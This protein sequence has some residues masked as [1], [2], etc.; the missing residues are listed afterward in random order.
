MTS[1][2]APGIAA[3][4]A[5]DMAGGVPRSSA[6]TIA[7]VG[8]CIAAGGRHIDAAIASAQPT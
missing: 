8:A 6:P 4:M 7:S 3:T 2:R 5:S 1:S